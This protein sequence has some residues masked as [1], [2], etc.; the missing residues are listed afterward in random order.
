MIEKK[1]I[2]TIRTADISDLENILKLLKE[3]DLDGD[4]EMA[5]EDAKRLF[6]RIQQY[7]DYTIYLAMHGATAVGT[8]ALLIMD[9]LEHG[10]APSGIVDSVAVAH[11]YQGHGIGSAMML[12]AREVCRSKGCYKLMLSSNKNRIQAHE[13]YQKLGFNQHGFSFSIET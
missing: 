2:V 7:P 12:H 5:L 3:L 11:D 1:A 4:K 10:G 9:K 13:F 6:Q 8:Y